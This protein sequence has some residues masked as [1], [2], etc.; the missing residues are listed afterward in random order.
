MLII[1]FGRPCLPSALCFEGHAL[2]LGFIF[3]RPNKTS[4]HFQPCATSPRHTGLFQCWATSPGTVRA[5]AVGAQPAAHP[6]AVALWLSPPLGWRWKP[7]SAGLV[8]GHK[9]VVFYSPCFTFRPPTLLNRTVLMQR[10]LL[11]KQMDLSH[12]RFAGRQQAG[13]ATQEK[14]F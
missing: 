1:R 13:P 14:P 12:W 2:H 7:S 4:Q 11:C 10:L 9:A 8:G 6:H 5:A 3:L